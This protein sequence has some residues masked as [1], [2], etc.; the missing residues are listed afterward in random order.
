MS[1]RINKRM[2]KNTLLGALVNNITPIE[3]FRTTHPNDYRLRRTN[4]V[5]QRLHARSNG[6][7]VFIVEH[8]QLRGQEFELLPTLCRL[9]RSGPPNQYFTVVEREE[10][11]VEVPVEGEHIDN[12][13]EQLGEE[14][15]DD[16]E[17]VHDGEHN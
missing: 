14:P 17:P 8:V 6:Q 4:F 16:V 11:L 13:P 12:P 10:Q 1:S 9:E 15:E 2:D 3:P 7:K 5:V